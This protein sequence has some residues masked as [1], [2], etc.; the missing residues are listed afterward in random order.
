MIQVHSHVWPSEW[1]VKENLAVWWL[2]CPVS[3]MWKWYPTWSVN[4]SCISKPIRLDGKGIDKNPFG[5]G[6][7]YHVRKRRIPLMQKW[8]PIST[9]LSCIK[10]VEKQIPATTNQSANSKSSARLWN[11]SLLQTLNSS[12][13]PMALCSII[14]F[15]SDQVTPLQAGVPQ[16]SVLHPVLVLVF[17]N[18]LSDS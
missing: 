4:K 3:P 5:S 17:I 10:K 2:K 16:G 8:K 11:P 9:L 14:N 15:V 7:S 12:L 18:D 6:P 13:S 1:T